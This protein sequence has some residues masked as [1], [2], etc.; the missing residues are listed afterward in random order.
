MTL[1]LKHGGKTFANFEP[2]ALLA[3]GVPQAVIDTAQSEIRRKAVSAECRRR[4]YAGASVEA[5]LNLTAATSAIAATQEAD[6][7]EDDLAVLSGA[8]A[9]IDWVSTM[10]AK[11]VVLAADTDANHLEDATWPALSAEAQVVIGRF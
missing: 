5:Q 11:V 7:T 1:T 9:V 6:R 2:D 8:T 3:A 4:I 10:R